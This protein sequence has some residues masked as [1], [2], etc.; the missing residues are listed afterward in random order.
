MIV[1]YIRPMPSIRIYPEPHDPTRAEARDQAISGAHAHF[2]SVK[3]GD[4]GFRVVLAF[5]SKEGAQCD[6]ILTPLMAAGLQAEIARVLDAGRPWQYD[7]SH[8]D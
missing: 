4:G 1:M 2:A 3:G 7:Q 5:R 6:A 8:E